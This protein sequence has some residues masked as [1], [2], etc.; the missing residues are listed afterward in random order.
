M[1]T[2]IIICSEFSPYIFENVILKF[3]PFLQYH[4]GRGIFYVILGTFC[5]DPAMGWICFFAGLGLIVCGFLYVIASRLD[6]RKQVMT[7][8]MPK[9]TT[10][11]GAM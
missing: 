5:I 6:H 2:F 9:V 4:A 1:F 10:V 8:T 7:V 3:F 11:S